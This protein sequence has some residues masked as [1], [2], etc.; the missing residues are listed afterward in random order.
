VG[1]R[2]KLGPEA[3]IRILAGE[4]LRVEEEAV[5]AKRLMRHVT[6]R[7]HGPLT[8]PGSAKGVKL[9]VKAATTKRLTRNGTSGKVIRGDA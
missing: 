4:L 8:R 6:F 7:G 5:K 1:E 2:R 3:L 9:V